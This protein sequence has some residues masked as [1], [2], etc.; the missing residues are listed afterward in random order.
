MNPQPTAAKAPPS[1]ANQTAVPPPPAAKKTEPKKDLLVFITHREGKCTECGEELF[2]G[3]WIF[4]DNEK[5]LC[6]SCA[7]F[8]RLAYLPSG[9]TALTRRATKHSPMRAVVLQWSRSRKRYERQGILVA[10]DALA[11]AETECLADADARERQRARAAEKR[12]ALEPAY[13]N[14]VAGAI[15]AQYPA[16]PSDEAARIAEWTCQKHSGRIGRTAAAK[17]LDP[18]AL[19]LAVVAHIRHEHTAYDSILMRTGEREAARAQVAG[20]IETILERWGKTE[21]L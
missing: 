20:K 2:P 19:R 12:A 16:C 10:P 15:R 14:A 3:N 1:T 21:T 17:E 11:R 7:G 9:N 4:L 5:L 18:R 6:M 8:D 13:A